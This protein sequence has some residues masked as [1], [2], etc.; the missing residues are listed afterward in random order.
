MKR[1]LAHIALA[2]IASPLI[3]L[4]ACKLGDH[5]PWVVFVPPLGV[6]FL[7]TEAVF[8]LSRYPR[9]AT[10]YECI[11]CAA[12]FVFTWLLLMAVLRLSEKLIIQKREIA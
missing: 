10:S 8:G 9:H 7:C 12:Y 11:V 3:M 1:A 4:L 6:G 2:G 5:N